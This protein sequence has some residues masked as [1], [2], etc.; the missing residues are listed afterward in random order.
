MD[1]LNEYLKYSCKHYRKIEF[2]QKIEGS[3][4]SASSVIGIKN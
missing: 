2:E 3:A 4:I 1:E